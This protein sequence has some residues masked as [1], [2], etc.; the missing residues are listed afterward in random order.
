MGHALGPVLLDPHHRVTV[1][2]R[3][4][5][6]SQ[7]AADAV[8]S[9]CNERNN[10]DA[11]VET[12]AVVAAA[13]FVAVSIFQMALALGAPWGRLAWGGQHRRLPPKLRIGSGVAALLIVI[14]A[15]VIL[16]RGGRTVG[17][18]EDVLPF[19]VFYWGTWV[20]VGQLFLNT[21]ANLASSSPAEKYVMGAFTCA[22]AGL[23]VYVALS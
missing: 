1:G 10:V 12:A 2:L 20:I 8:V 19:G 21:L 6:T 4:D 23:C 15:A 5:W 22:E 18:M 11:S 14:F 16:G 3:P 13:G 9:L 17:P 7:H